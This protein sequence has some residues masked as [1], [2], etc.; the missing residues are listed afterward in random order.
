MP[1]SFFRHLYSLLLCGIIPLV[2]S[3][4]GYIDDRFS[5]SSQGDTTTVTLGA[6]S[7]EAHA[8]LAGVRA[9]ALPGGI[10]IYAVNAQNPASRGAIKLSNELSSRTWKIPNGSYRFYA[11]GYTA[12]NFG[13]DLYCAASPVV[14][15]TGTE[16]TVTLNLTKATCATTNFI[17]SSHIDPTP[18]DQPLQLLLVSCSTSVTLT[19]KAATNNCLSG[20]EPGLFQSFKVSMPEFDAFTGEIAVVES[21]SNIESACFTA[22]AGAHATSSVRIPTGAVANAPFLIGINAFTDTA[23]A[24]TT[25]RLYGFGFGLSNTNPSSMKFWSKASGTDVP[26]NPAGTQHA[27]I[28]SDS[29]WIF[30]FLRDF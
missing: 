10:M 11:V 8:D 14:T 22:T 5:R 15:L 12:T 1:A 17:P 24:A 7:P 26:F 13:G 29:S 18:T 3:S 16:T 21:G 20:G 2:G 23:C 4:C 9:T 30:V 27:H 28:D 25:R 19:S 6:N